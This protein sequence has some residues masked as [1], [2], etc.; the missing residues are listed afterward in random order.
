MGLRADINVIDLENLELKVPYMAADLPTN[1]SR[2]MQAAEGYRMTLLAGVVT[3]EDGVP[4][5]ALPG[6][7][8]RAPLRA[9]L[10]VTPYEQL[11]L[12]AIAGPEPRSTHDTMLAPEDL[13]GGASSIATA[14]KTNS[15]HM[16][17]AAKAKAGAS[18]MSAFGDFLSGKML[19]KEASDPFERV[20]QQ[21]AVVA[22]ASKL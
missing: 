18:G 7:L 4:T 5:G 17:R 9:H 2:W 6:R 14:M 16:Q 8:V 13:T 1:A 20:K 10:A 22:P 3:F 15:A 12:A 21:Q 11:D 19:Q